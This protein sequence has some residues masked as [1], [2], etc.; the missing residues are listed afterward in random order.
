MS[1]ILR[2]VSWPF[3]N[4]R[5]RRVRALWRFALFMALLFATA[6]AAFWA[7]GRAGLPMRGLEI[8]PFLVRSIINFVLG[9]AFVAGC[10]LLLD[11]RGLDALGWVPSPRWWADLAF[12]AFLGAALIS[13]VVAIERA[14]GWLAPVAAHEGASFVFLLKALGLFVA[15]GAFEEVVFRSYM[16]RN[17]ADG[18]NHRRIGPSLAIAGGTLLSSALFG[19]GHA[20]NPNATVLSSVNIALAGVFLAAGYVLTGRLALPVGLHVAWNYFQGPVFGVPVSGFDIGQSILKHT[21][22][23]PALW[24]GGAF[25]IEGGLLGLFAMLAGVAATA[26]WVRWRE[27]ALALATSLLFAERPPEPAPTPLPQAPA[28][29]TGVLA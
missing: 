11:R 14:A 15:A 8:E 6:T 3:W 17:F 25:G 18:L 13:V 23:G 12:G 24:T 4:A 2:V 7:A 5:Q 20:S 21:Q 26:A 29:E 22:G 9:T 27:G 16:L 19:L 10:T 1:E 28:E